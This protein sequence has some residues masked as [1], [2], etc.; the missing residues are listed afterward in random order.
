MF[1]WVQPL[2]DWVAQH[3]SWA[4]LIIVAVSFADALFL[5][6]FLFPSPVILFGVGALI[7]LN[8]LDLWPA[9]VCAAIGAMLG[10]LLNF[11]IGA[12][13]GKRILSTNFAERY[14]ESIGSARRFFYRHGAK[15][16]ILGRLI[17]LIRPLV[18]AV[19]AASGMRLLTF[20]LWDVVACSVWAIAFTFPG[21]AVGAS[22]HLA[23]EIATRFALL[24]MFAFA[25]V[26][27]LL[28]L[29]RIVARY[30]QH[31][32]EVWVVWLLRWSGRH[33]RFGRLGAWLADPDQPETPALL[34]LAGLF[35]I[36][37]WLGLGLIWLLLRGHP[38]PIDAIVYQTLSD[39]HAPW[40]RIAA[41]W[42]TV[43]GDVPVMLVSA[44]AAFVTLLW[45]RQ[46]RA[47]AH[48]AAGVAFGA[49]IAVGLYA[50]VQIAEPAQ[51]YGEGAAHSRFLGSDLILTTVVY[52]LIPVLLSVGR[53]DRTRTR[54][55][56]I[57]VAMVG[58]IT[59]SQ[60][61]LGLQWFSTAAFA[62]A[63]GLLWTLVLA[64]GYRRHNARRVPG[65]RFFMPVFVSFVVAV[66]LFAPLR[67]H[68]P[69][70]PGLPPQQM[71][72]QHWLRGGFGEL[73]AYRGDIASH[74][75]QPLN[76][77]WR[78]QL[79][80]IR[81]ALLAADWRE[82]VHLTPVTA[83][84]MLASE[85]VLSDLPVLPQIHNGRHPDLV[86][87][88][89]REHD[90]QQTPREAVL[91]LWASGWS[92]DGLPLWVGGVTTQSAAALVYLLQVP[93]T[94]QNYDLPL[95][96]LQAPPGFAETLVV[97]PAYERDPG[98]WSGTIR[99]LYPAPQADSGNENDT[100]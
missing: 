19:A 64:V 37:G 82:P 44:A 1:D 94:L 3:P 27:T 84:R 72:A 92:A 5:L 49:V 7:A 97:H 77:Q 70:L 85:T 29:T 50:G 42:I 78:G 6:G 93:V 14:R 48:L 11:A 98:R 34:I 33:R 35:L 51:F 2:L 47:A 22:L 4:L 80:D 95:L 53:S 86:L 66:V 62:V 17:G 26:W 24:L 76:L 12:R 40:G 96:A 23:A 43:L 54:Y 88:R 57:A 91:R 60:L 59:A 45:L 68:A 30:A 61:Y 65:R 89:V 41:S 21:I 31:H 32:A 63:I 25:L 74:H 15:G 36:A 55:Y 81:S 83:L 20:M 87:T 38:Q 79:G 100:N 52:G 16:I 71:S 69:G 10:D 73:P 67:A 90:R 18:P 28:F 39:L 46:G 75:S 8:A 58:L 99:L 13:Y 56:G 9:L